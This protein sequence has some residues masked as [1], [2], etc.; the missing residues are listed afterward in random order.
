MSWPAAAGPARS[1][2]S[3]LADHGDEGDGKECGLVKTRVGAPDQHQALGVLLAQGQ[4]QP[5]AEG[6]LI[7]ERLRDVV[8]CGGDENR[9]VRGV[10]WSALITVASPHLHFNVAQLLQLLRWLVFHPLY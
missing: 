8:R 5:P 1:L 3:S 4:D 6:E 7:Q 10:L 2:F 9:G